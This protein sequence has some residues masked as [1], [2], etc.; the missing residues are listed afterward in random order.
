MMQPST[1]LA[2]HPYGEHLVCVGQVCFLIQQFA[3]KTILYQSFMLSFFFH[4][5]HTQ[6]IFKQCLKLCEG[7]RTYIRSM[8][9]TDI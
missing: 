1:V 9:S 8:S 7:I 3:R 2:H 4:A 6:I 5:N